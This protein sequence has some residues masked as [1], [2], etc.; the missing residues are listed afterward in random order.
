MLRQITQK[1]G[2]FDV[3]SQRDYPN[4]VWV[5][6]AADAGMPL[7]KFSRGIESNAVL[8]SALKGRVHI[9]KRL[10]ATQ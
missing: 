2:R 7:D 6:I 8:Q 10:G 9:H 3:G 1:V 4:D 5:K